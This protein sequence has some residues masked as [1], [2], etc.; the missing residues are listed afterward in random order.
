MIF[1]FHCC[2]RRYFLNRNQ[3]WINI[4]RR[5]LSVLEKRFYIVCTPNTSIL[6]SLGHGFW[7]ELSEIL[8]RF[9]GLSDFFLRFY[10]YILAYRDWLPHFTW[11]GEK[12]IERKCRTNKHSP[13][14]ERIWFSFREF[15]IKIRH[16]KK[17]NCNQKH[18]LNLGKLIRSGGGV[19][20]LCCHFWLMNHIIWWLRR[21][22]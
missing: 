10:V 18:R 12:E 4:I 19:V 5:W 16:L 11:N 15:K 8:K 13:H 6:W 17:K 14:Q 21:M 9:E 2:C 7:N 3:Y 20:V 22:K 1:S